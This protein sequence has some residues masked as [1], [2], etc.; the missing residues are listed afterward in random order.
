MTKIDQFLQIIEA[1]L[2]EK[3]GTKSAYSDEPVLKPAN[4][5]S[6]YVPKPIRE[7]EAQ[8]K[9]FNPFKDSKEALFY[10][11][12]KQMEWYEDDCPYH[13][14]LYWCY[15]TY[16]DLNVHLLRGYFTW[17]TQYRRGEI[18]PTT[19]SYLYLYAQE[20]VHLIGVASPEEGYAALGKLIEAYENENT[21]YASVCRV[22]TTWRLDFLAYYGLDPA[23]VDD[24]ADMAYDRALIKLKDIPEDD[25][26]LFDAI[27]ALSSYHAERSAFYKAYPED[28]RQVVCGVY[29]AQS[30]YAAKN[31]KKTYFEKLFGYR[32]GYYHPMFQN[33]VVF[34]TR[35]YDDYVYELNAVH[36][37]Y[38]IQ[39]RWYCEKYYGDRT[40]SKELGKLLKII[41]AQ[42]RERYGFARQIKA[43]IPTKQMQKQIEGVIQLQLDRRKAQEKRIVHL[44]LS[45]L[46][47][48]RK[49][50]E[51]TR[52]LLIVEE[53]SELSERTTVCNPPVVP[54]QSA[55]SPG[56]GLDETE[57]ELLRCLLFGKD[58]AALLRERHLILSVVA[59]GMNDKLYEMFG[60][61]PIVFEGDTP[62]ILEDYT[63]ELKGLLQE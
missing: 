31:R 20:L 54:I 19:S 50:A 46:G 27:C 8:K 60:D 57:K 61:T 53:E 16:Q 1:A 4:K 48:I 36:R 41:D 56:C 40:N 17:R 7:L 9:A 38:C 33:A 45:Q 62:V 30:A 5:M 37:Y 18:A 21:Q 14:E 39:R 34:Y 35:K 10:R 25:Q 43:E 49:A 47:E 29:R 32:T 11:Q 44:D 63:V 42:M 23:L 52:D 13:G 26:E 59:D 15:L 58:Y 55:E 6:N 12:A 51:T 28:Y 24:S 3:P 22:L 2:R